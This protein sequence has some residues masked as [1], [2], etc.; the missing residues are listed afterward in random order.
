M[1]FIKPSKLFLV[2]SR[3]GLIGR[4]AR[5][6]LRT[7]F[8]CDVSPGAKFAGPPMLHHPLGIVVGMGVTIGRDATI[9]HGVTIG[10]S[11]AGKYPK[12]GN[13]VTIYPN[14]MIVGGVII[15]D[16]VIIGANAFV[17]NDV[18]SNAIVRSLPTEISDSD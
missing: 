4:M 6:L 5:Y 7:L 1:M 11:R 16:N 13:N 12:I 10:A 8:S 14:A 17:I 9:Y 15:G 3:G 18:P 2:V